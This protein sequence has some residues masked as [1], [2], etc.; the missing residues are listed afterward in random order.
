MIVVNSVSKR[1][2][3]FQVLSECSMRVARGE[4]VAVDENLAI[5]IVE[6]VRGTG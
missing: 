1:F 5:R 6:I 3:R 4:I 2:N